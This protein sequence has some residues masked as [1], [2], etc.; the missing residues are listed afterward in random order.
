VIRLREAGLSD[1]Q[2]AR[3]HAPI[4]LPIGGRT[5]EEI[6]LSIMAQIVAVR[7]GKSL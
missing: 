5:P 4:G 1:N 6:G 2:I 3:L 7:N